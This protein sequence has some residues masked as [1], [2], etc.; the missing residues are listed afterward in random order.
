MAPMAASTLAAGQTVV[1][2]GINLGTTDA[3]VGSNQRGTNTEA[4]PDSQFVVP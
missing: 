2:I 3:E 1:P 4:N